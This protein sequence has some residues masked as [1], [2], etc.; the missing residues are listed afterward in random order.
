MDLQDVECLGLDWIALT[1]DRDSWRTVVN[2][3]MKLRV[4]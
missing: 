3:V 1:E 2:V 4:S